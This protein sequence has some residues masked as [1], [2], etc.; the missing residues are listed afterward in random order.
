[1]CVPGVSRDA[2]DRIQA[3]VASNKDAVL[4]PEH[5]AEDLE[6]SQGIKSD[7][8]D[9][10][11]ENSSNDEADK[12]ENGLFQPHPY[13]H[14]NWQD[15]FEPKENGLPQKRNDSSPNGATSIPDCK[16]SVANGNLWD[17]SPYRR[18]S[19]GSRRASIQGPQITPEAAEAA[20]A[21]AAS[22]AQMTPLL[23][24]TFGPLAVLLGIPSL[25]QRWHGEVLDPPLNPNGTSNFIE[26]PDPALNLILAGISLFCEVMGNTLLVLRFSNFHTKITTWVSYAF[27]IA[28]IVFGISNYV[29]FGIAHPETENIIYLQG[30]WVHFM[31]FLL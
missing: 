17:V 15:K 6:T 9:A 18:G 30:F 19:A 11:D 27:W 12:L 4:N 28:K 13:P 23:A 8:E 24:A 5:E 31:N 26:L 20:R 22:W 14:L 10:K 21:E 2:A 3:D 25:T 29:Q 16:E 1:M 7:A